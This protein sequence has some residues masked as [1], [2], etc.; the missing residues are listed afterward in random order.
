MAGSDEP[1]G[2]SG[3]EPEESLPVETWMKTHGDGLD[4]M[5]HDVLLLE[6]GGYLIVGETTGGHEAT[7]VSCS[8][9]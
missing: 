1:F 8:S 4:T 2:S 3:A 5:G 6:D 7:P 9:G